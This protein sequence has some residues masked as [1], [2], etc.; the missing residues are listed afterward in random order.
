MSRESIATE[1][2]GFSYPVLFT[3]SNYLFDYHRNIT[4]INEFLN[5]SPDTMPTSF[6]YKLASLKLPIITEAIDG[7]HIK[8]GSIN[9]L[10]LYGNLNSMICT[11]CM[12]ICNKSNW[13]KANQ[14]FKCPKCQSPLRPDIVLPGEN[15]RNFH[16]ALNEVYKCDLI[17]VIGSHL[18]NWPANKLVSKA[19]QNGSKLLMYND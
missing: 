6:H 7:L 9:V 10:E 5:T 12:F 15:L 19:I 17:I 18:K 3:G 8:A 2:K 1:I 14:F 13:K 4:T 11:K 16:L